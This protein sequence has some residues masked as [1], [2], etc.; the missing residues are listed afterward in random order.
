MS[1]EEIVSEFKKLILCESRVNEPIDECEQIFNKITAWKEKA[2]DLDQQEKMVQKKMKPMEPIIVH[3]HKSVMLKMYELQGDIGLTD[4]EI[5][6][7]V[8][9]SLDKDFMNNLIIS[10]GE[11]LKWFNTNFKGE[12]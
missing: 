12:S 8:F 7:I 5:T 3:N 9:T 1:A 11:F 10:Q 6:I 4:D 2:G